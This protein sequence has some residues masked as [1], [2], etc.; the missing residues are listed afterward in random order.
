ML[1]GLF[2]PPDM[3]SPARFEGL[4]RWLD[5]HIWQT[6]ADDVP[7][8]RLLFN[9]GAVFWLCGLCVLAAAFAGDWRRLLVLAL[10][11]LLYMRASGRKDDEPPDAAL[12]S[13]M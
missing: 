7:V 4:R 11:V 13:E 9:T 8:V 2:A 12:M 3:S 6:G 10:P 1:T 5:E